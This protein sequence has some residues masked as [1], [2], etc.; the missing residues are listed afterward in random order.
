MAS[1]GADAPLI[2][3]HCF[4]TPPPATDSKSV[5]M[6]EILKREILLLLCIFHF[7]LVHSLNRHQAMIAHPQQCMAGKNYI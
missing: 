2:L 5:V 1:G 6:E 4:H 3:T 7:S